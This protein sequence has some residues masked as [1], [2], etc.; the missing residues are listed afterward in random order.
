MTTY[1]RW[2]VT[3]AELY[4]YSTGQSFDLKDLVREV[5]V[6]FDMDR[7]PFTSLRVTLNDPGNAVWQNMDPRNVDWIFSFVAE[8][9]DESGA[10]VLP[11]LRCIYQRILR[12]RRDY[13][14]RTIVLECGGW[15]TQLQERIRL[16]ETP[17][18]TGG[19]NLEQ[20]IFSALADV[21]TQVPAMD[22]SYIA[23]V[24][25]AGW[26]I[27]A[28]DRRLMMPGETF[29]QFLDREINPAGWR[30]RSDEGGN[31]II[32]TADTVRLPVTHPSSLALT[33]TGPNATVYEFTETRDRTGDYADGVIMR[34]DWIS[35]TTRNTA[36]RRSGSG[37]NT[38]GQQINVAAPV[39]GG[40]PADNVAARAARRGREFVTRAFLNPAAFPGQDLSVTVPNHDGTFTAYTSQIR[41][42]EYNLEIGGPAEMTIKSQ[43]TAAA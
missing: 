1:R 12:V 27:P 31:W 15:E 19:A 14:E 28:G 35:G 17:L 42:V 37:L 23:S 16:A 20:R 6:S 10:A 8:Q 2:Q 32:D 24:A 21:R 34:F 33:V 36:Y 3:R 5:S 11:T 43:T 22:G 29:W 7:I 26:L 25:V 18:T 40:N 9:V 4:P 38:K 39:P 41:A 30:M 13:L